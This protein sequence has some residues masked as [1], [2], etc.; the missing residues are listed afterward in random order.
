MEVNIY[1]L[2]THLSRFLQYLVDEKEE[3]IIISKSGKPFAK[4]TLL[5]SPISKRIGAAKKEMKDF[6]ISLETFNDLKIDDF[7]DYLWKFY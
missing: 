7:D 4:I 3:Q 1:D 2:K 6:D 5:D